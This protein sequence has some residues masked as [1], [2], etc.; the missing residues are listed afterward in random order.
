[1]IRSG[2]P[3]TEPLLS[4]FLEPPY[5]ALLTSTAV[6]SFL[7]SSSVSPGSSLLS[8]LKKKKKTCIKAREARVSHRC[9]SREVMQVKPRAFSLLEL[10]T[11]SDF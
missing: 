2:L 3:A 10:L 9:L 5:P 4:A 1:M 7:L 11:E 8:F 6:T